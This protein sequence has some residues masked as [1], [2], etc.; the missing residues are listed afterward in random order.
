MEIGLKVRDVWE[1]GQIETVQWSLE[2]HQKGEA[3]RRLRLCF[4]PLLF[5]LNLS[6]CSLSLGEDVEHAVPRAVGLLHCL[7][8]V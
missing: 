5:S 3:R 8:V 4:Q 1:K 6:S 2:L 7:T